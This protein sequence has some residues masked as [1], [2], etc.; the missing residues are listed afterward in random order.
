[1]IHGFLIKIYD[2][3]FELAAGCRILD[4]ISK[5]EEGNDPDNLFLGNKNKLRDL[6]QRLETH[7]RWPDFHS[8]PRRKRNPGTCVDPLDFL[9]A[10]AAKHAHVV[11]SASGG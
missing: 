3:Y 6:K 1:M 5:F 9:N 8:N 7:W 10:S 2:T 11:N 4:G